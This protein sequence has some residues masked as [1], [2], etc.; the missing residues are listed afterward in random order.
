MSSFNWYLLDMTFVMRYILF[1]TYIFGHLFYSIEGLIS[2]LKSE[3]LNTFQK[4]FNGIMVF[5]LPVIWFNLIK[6]FLTVEIDVVTKK[7]RDE[8]RRKNEKPFNE[9]YTF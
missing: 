2:V 8:R 5:L 4:V 3:F 9:G 6:S 7:E 1:I